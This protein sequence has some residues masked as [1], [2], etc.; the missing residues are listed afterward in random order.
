MS[1]AAA[2]VM[3]AFRRIAAAYSDIKD[4]H[5]IIRESIALE[6]A[7]RGVT[8]REIAAACGWRSVAH[9]SELESG[10]RNWT[11]AGAAKA[12]AFMEKKGGAK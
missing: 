5:T 3:G 1:A 11:Q 9:V 12:L 4:D 2:E 7:R 8:M 6:R 10:T